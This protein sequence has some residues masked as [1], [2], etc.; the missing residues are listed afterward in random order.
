MDTVSTDSR[1]IPKFQQ[2]KNHIQDQINWKVIEPGER[3]PSEAELAEM[4]DVSIITVRR[5][6]AELVN[7]DAIY[8]IQG[9]G[10]F[11]AHPSATET[12]N[13][14]SKR[15]IAFVLSHHE[16]YDSSLMQMIKGIQ[17]YLNGKGFSL[18]IEY[19][20][21]D[22]QKEREIIK[23]L[24]DDGISGLII[25]SGNPDE[26]I[27][28]LDDL[29]KRNFPFVLL[30]RYTKLLPVNYVGSN[31][32]DGAYRAGEYLIS[33]GHTR[34]GFIEYSPHITSE[35]ERLHGYLQAMKNSSLSIDRDLVFP[36]NFQ[37]EEKLTEEILDRGITAVMVVNDFL[38]T[39]L[40]D[41][42]HR[43]GVGIP[44]QLSI[45]GFDDIDSAKYQKVP[46]STVKQHFDVMGRQAAKV[47]MDIIKLSSLGTQNILLPTEIVI[48]DSADVVKGQ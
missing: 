7:E 17:S 43:Q 19:T 47:L 34:I 8:R 16:C 45:I 46:L 36:Y 33:L 24:M 27:E 2:I 42:C 35:N 21:E 5:A 38:A 12:K 18:I 15:L 23:R 10:T 20:D 37:S 28:I 6:L 41:V 25:F 31:N 1:R 40:M 30:D 11:V 26:N 48:R 44:D 4:F 13:D 29:R 22:L 39:Q 9:K 14:I 32:F 3:L